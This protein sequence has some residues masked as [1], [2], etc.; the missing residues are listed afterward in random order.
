MLPKIYRIK[1]VLDILDNLKLDVSTVTLQDINLH[2]QSV[3]L[4]AFVDRDTYDPNIFSPVLKKY[5]NWLREEHL[6]KNYSQIY[7]DSDRWVYNS[8]F[9]FEEIIRALNYHRV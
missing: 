4:L 6:Q 7:Y 2:W 8:F 9:S 1:V 5:I 3:G